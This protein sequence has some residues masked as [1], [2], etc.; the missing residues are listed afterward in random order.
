[1]D[2]VT[3]LE[4]Y[5]AEKEAQRETSVIAVTNTLAFDEN[6]NSTLNGKPLNCSGTYDGSFFNLQTVS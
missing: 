3:N 6:G 2:N 5:K 4:Q 1:M